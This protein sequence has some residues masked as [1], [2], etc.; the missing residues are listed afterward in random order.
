MSKLFL[1]NKIPHDYNR[2][3]WAEMLTQIETAV[4]RI[5]DG[6]LFPVSEGTIT[7]DYT[8]PLG[9]SFVPV[10]ASGGAVTITLRPAAEEENRRITV[11]KIDSS[12]NNVIVDGNGSE[13]V[14][15]ATTAVITLQYES[16]CLY[17][18]GTEWWVV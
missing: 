17:S 15:D 4:N 3:A 12:P 8:I 2:Q 14:D 18:D 10:D 6:F 9:T 5:M 7:G 16:I 13:T 11:K 1:R